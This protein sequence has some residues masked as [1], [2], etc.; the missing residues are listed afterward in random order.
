MRGSGEI[1]PADFR[2]GQ[3]PDLRCGSEP[4]RRR[5]PKVSRAA[6]RS[7]PPRART[8]RALIVALALAL[9]LFG[10][11]AGAEPKVLKIGVTPARPFVEGKTPEQ[12]TGFDIE[13]WKALSKELGWDAKDSEV[14]FEFVIV[15][16]FPELF[17]RVEKGETD[18]AM[19][20]ITIAS[21]REKR[22][23]FSYPYLDSGLAIMT[24]AGEG[25]DSDLTRI[26]AN[27]FGS[28][29]VW[30]ILGVVAVFVLL[31]AHVIWFVER[32]SDAF[33]DHYVQGIAEGC[34]WAVVTMTTVGYGDKVPMK[35]TSRIAATVIMI[36]G[37]MTF[38][39]F[40]A[41]IASSLAV[42]E[43]RS[44]L[45]GPEDFRRRTRVSVARGT[46]SETFVTSLKHK[47][48]VIRRK[49]GVAGAIESLKAGEVD[50]VV[51]DA[52]MLRFLAQEDPKL[53]VESRTF[54][55]Q[56]YGILL[57]LGSP[58]RKDINCALLALEK[59]GTLE[60][61]RNRWFPR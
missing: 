15:E 57:K 59:D 28:K 24:R 21:E 19:A 14:Q 56:K 39:T 31:S 42:E 58:W 11:D 27:F 26:V 37:I 36:V 40:T 23:D 5:E 18:L 3:R 7:Q 32:G 17:D 20:S 45:R 50:G 54:A 16:Q 49:D 47:P 29:A 30:Q 34:W 1:L 25:V 61:L 9:G 8:L 22:F 41:V 13:L 44:S 33:S 43:A 4:V 52:P 48:G 55:P 60:Q 38:S 46:T 53:V 2:P 6:K 10:G 51:H 35:L 12:L